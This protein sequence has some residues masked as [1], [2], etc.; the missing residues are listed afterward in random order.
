M[1]AMTDGLETRLYEAGWR[2]RTGEARRCGAL[3]S[4]DEPEQRQAALWFHQ[5]L[6]RSGEDDVDPGGARLGGVR[7]GSTG[8]RGRP[9]SC[10]GGWRE[11]AQVDL[12]TLL[13]EF[14]PL[15]RRLWRR[16][17]GRGIRPGAVRSLRRWMPSAAATVRGCGSRSTS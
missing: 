17:H 13:R 5:E 3:E 6:S 8:L 14:G 11:R 7:S 4:L 2:E 10:S 15:V 1:T 9:T 12:L 16:P